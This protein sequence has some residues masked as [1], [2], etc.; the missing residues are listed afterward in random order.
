M[1]L[2]AHAKGQ[3]KEMPNVPP[4]QATDTSKKS[5]IHSHTE[6]QPGPDFDLISNLQKNVHYPYAARQHNTEGRVIVKF[7]IN[8]DGSVSDVTILRGLGNG[9]DEEAARVVNKMPKWKPGKQDGKA[10]KV[11]FT[12]PIQ[13]KLSDK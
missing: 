5:T 3:Q 11:Y 13:F 8:E 10:V 7:V 4:A 6:E 9:C 1:L 12:L 2:A